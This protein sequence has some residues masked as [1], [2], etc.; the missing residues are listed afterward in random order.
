MVAAPNPRTWVDKEIPPYSTWNRDLY[1]TWQF[2]L[3][4]PMVKSRQTTAQLILNSV[5]TSLNF[6]VDEIDT[7]GAHSSLWPSRFIAQVPGYYV[8]YAGAS[9]AYF[10]GGQREVGVA[11]NLGSCLDREQNMYPSPAGT[12][13]TKG[14]SFGPW[15]F[16][17]TTDFIEVKVYQTFGTSGIL[18]DVGTGDTDYERPPEFYMRWWSS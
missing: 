4:P 13:A 11:M 1:A 8:G 14:V 3:N 6:Q 12:Y 10:G 2:L 5:W 15:Y 16:N 18:T 7:H 9:F 17:G